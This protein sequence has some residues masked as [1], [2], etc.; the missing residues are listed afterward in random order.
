MAKDKKK[1]T[2]ELRK[3]LLHGKGEKA[4]MA[5]FEAMSELIRRCEE[6]T[7]TEKERQ[8]LDNWNIETGEDMLAIEECMAFSAEEEEEMDKRVYKKIAMA[9]NFPETDWIKMK[10]TV[11]DAG[12]PIKM[13]VIPNKNKMRFMRV[14]GS[15]AAV[16]AVTV[17][18]G[19]SLYLNGR[20]T[21]KASDEILCENLS[22]ST[23][24]LLN[25]DSR[26][27]I[28]EDF[29]EE[30]RRVKMEG[31][32]Y[33]EVAK[34]AAIPFLIDHGVLETQVKGT[35]FTICDYPEMS[36][37]TVTVRTGVVAV[38]DWKG[39]QLRELTKGM[40]MV[41]NKVDSTNY[42]RKDVSWEDASGW[43]SGNIVLTAADEE[44][45]ALRL[46][47]TYHYDVI[48]EKGTFNKGMRF[49]T[50][51]NNKE[52]VDTVMKRLQMI[53]GVRYLIEDGRMIL[54]R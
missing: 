1:E 13:K 16:F 31:E 8:L 7:A 18:I 15:V 26:L 17:L 5:R 49:Y 22:D 27:T 45:L 3:L 53:Y 19:V 40:Q 4:R 28:A 52:S 44:E 42:V 30:A 36:T 39:K 14:Y 37:S 12:E 41:Y 38:K 33:F 43:M 51:F 48:I 32:I 24:V 47:Q 35:S 2:N 6:G 34:N 25:Q 10:E 29:G 50:R 11:K 20:N 21:I 9:C 23:K 54:S 46:K